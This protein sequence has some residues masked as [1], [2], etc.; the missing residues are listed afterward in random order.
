MSQVVL[1]IKSVSKY[2]CTINIYD[3]GYLQ[4]QT[5]SLDSEQLIILQTLP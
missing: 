4:T 5:M 1:D 2:L 3:G